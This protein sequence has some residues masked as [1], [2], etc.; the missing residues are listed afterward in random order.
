MKNSSLIGYTILFLVALAMPVM[1]DN[2]DDENRSL[3]K[4]P[5]DLLLFS[6][7]GEVNNKLPTFSNQP[8]LSNNVI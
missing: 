8:V 6:G 1:G 4:N 5:K 7:G 3:S 2:I